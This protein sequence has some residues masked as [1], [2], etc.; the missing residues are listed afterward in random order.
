VPCIIHIPLQTIHLSS[1]EGGLCQRYQPW[2]L[3]HT[4]FSWSTE[5]TFLGGGKQYLHSTNFLL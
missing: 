4:T 3:S 2:V 1:T 5:G